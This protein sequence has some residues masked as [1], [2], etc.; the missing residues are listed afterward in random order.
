MTAPQ[1]LRIPIYC[2]HRVVSK[3]T[4]DCPWTLST[5]QFEKQMHRLAKQGYQT[6]SLT[7][8]CN[9]QALST[10]LPR[11]PL[12]LTFDDGH[13]GFL[14]LAAPT[15][16]KH[17]FRAT[18]FVIGG[19]LGQE[20]HLKGGPPFK[21]MSRKQASTLSDIGFD[22]ENHGLNHLNWTQIREDDLRREISESAD[23][24]E[25]ATGRTVKFAAYPYGHVT[26]HV[27]SVVESLGYLAA[28]TTAAG[29]NDFHTDRFLLRRYQIVNGAGKYFLRWLLHR[30]LELRSEFFRNTSVMTN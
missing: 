6:I 7:D 17:N 3:G 9:W 4:E 21:I 2:Y 16:I 14:E 11:K 28:C 15:L 25:Q 1:N 26:P 27:R 13:D 5:M 23:I 30:S 20:V 12:I 8:F 19:Q 24:L 29:R 22:I 10:K 18:I